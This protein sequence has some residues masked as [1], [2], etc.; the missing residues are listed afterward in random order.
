[1]YCKNCGKELP[2]G[3]EICLYCGSKTNSAT[4]NALRTAAKILMLLDVI[5]TF[6]GGIFYFIA[7]VASADQ[8]GTV[9][10]FLLMMPIGIGTLISLVWKI[11]MTVFYWKNVHDGMGGSLGLKI[12]TLIFVDFTA[13]VL[14]L[15]DK[16]D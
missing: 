13:G 6:L 12:C 11:P 3:S 16:D 14:M 15:C 1:M 2:N 10:S 8:Y 7:P 4:T 9:L 5:G